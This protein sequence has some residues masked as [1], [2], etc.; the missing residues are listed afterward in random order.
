M[1]VA[2]GRFCSSVFLQTGRRYVCMRVCAKG[3]DQRTVQVQV[4][5]DGKWREGASSRAV[6]S[7][8]VDAFAS[9]RK[10][11]REKRRFPRFLGVGAS[12]A[13]KKMPGQD[14]TGH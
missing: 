10:S 9:G 1:T 11:T 12:K 7:T 8:E 4:Q 3:M 6:R 14:R 2:R 5:V 13:Q